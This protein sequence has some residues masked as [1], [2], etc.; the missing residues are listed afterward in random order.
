MSSHFF[1]SSLGLGYKVVH[2]YAEFTVGYSD[3]RPVLFGQQRELGRVTLYPAIGIAFKN[4]TP[5]QARSPPSD[6]STN[7]GKPVSMR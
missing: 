3:C 5:F 7:P 1:G 2:L 6:P 4:P